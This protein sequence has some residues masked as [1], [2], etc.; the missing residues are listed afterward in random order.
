MDV[1]I[2]GHMFTLDENNRYQNNPS[3][4]YKLKDGNK[5]R[6]VNKSYFNSIRNI[7]NINDPDLLAFLAGTCLDLYRGISGC[8]FSWE[9]LRKGILVSEGENDIPAMTMMNFKSRWLPATF[10]KT[11]AG[12]IARAADDYTK[13]LPGYIPVG[14]VAAIPVMNNPACF[15]N[16]S[17]IVVQGPLSAN[18]KQFDIDSILFLNA[19]IGNTQ[20]LRPQPAGSGYNLPPVRPYQPNSQAEINAWF[21]AAQREITS[22]MS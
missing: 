22:Y 20:Y 19:H 8:H 13:N 14:V 16:D 6:F 21:K 9:G 2:N 10:D 5:E 7:L 15:I 4:C 11:L 1:R 12:G 17:E 18:R 3:P